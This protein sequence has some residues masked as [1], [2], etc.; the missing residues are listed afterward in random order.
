MIFAKKFVLKKYLWTFNKCNNFILLPGIITKYT[1][2]SRIKIVDS[3][4]CRDFD[5]KP[6]PAIIKSIHHYRL[7]DIESFEDWQLYDILSTDNYIISQHNM[8]LDQIN[9]ILK[10]CAKCMLKYMGLQNDNDIVTLIY[11]NVDYQY[12]GRCNRF[13]QY[14]YNIYSKMYDYVKNLHLI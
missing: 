3:K 14:E 7:N 4:W 8:S 2:N 13:M 9:E 6:I 12:Q 1:E 5:Y 10:Q 11:I